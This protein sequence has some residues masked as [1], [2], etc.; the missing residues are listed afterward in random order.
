PGIPLLGVVSRFTH[1]KGTDLIAAALPELMGLPVQLAALGSGERS[2][3]DA[4][5]EAA[6]RYPGRVAV[7]IGFDNTLAHLIEAG[8]D[9]FVMPSRF[10][11]CGLNQ[12]Y[13]QRYGTP[14]IARATGGLADT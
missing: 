3:E 9:M 10:E 2:H 4:M 5:R 8:A 12:M 6:A 7:A 11:P 14:P 1:Q 13:S